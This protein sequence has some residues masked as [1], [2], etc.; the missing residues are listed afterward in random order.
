M[1]N[2]SDRFPSPVSDFIL[3][4]SRCSLA[5]IFLHEGIFLVMNFDAAASGMAKLGVPTPALLATILLQIAAGL[6]LCLGFYARIG[7]AA[8]GL[9]CL[10]TAFTFH[11][12]FDV[13]NELLHFEKDI[14]LAGG[15]FVL[16]L[17]GSGRWSVDG[18]WRVRS[19]FVNWISLGRQA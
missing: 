18:Q 1:I 8:L 6:S 7:S 2:F 16:M 19:L 12:H 13:R 4:A 3:L 9:F 5:W 15:M 11:T 17:Q 10:A 14:A